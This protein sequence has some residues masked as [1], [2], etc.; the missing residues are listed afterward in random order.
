MT[1]WQVQKA[2]IRLCE[3][4]EEADKQGPQ[5]ITW[6]GYERAV[7][8]SSTDYPALTEKERI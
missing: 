6:H 1:K 4:I 8:L 3:L 7:V 5:I 2:K